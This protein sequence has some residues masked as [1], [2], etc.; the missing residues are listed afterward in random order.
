MLG[1]LEMQSAESEK[2]FKNFVKKGNIIVYR[3]SRFS[4]G[5]WLEEQ[6]GGSGGKWVKKSLWF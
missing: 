2:D 3:K 5:L 6:K 4:S 1:E